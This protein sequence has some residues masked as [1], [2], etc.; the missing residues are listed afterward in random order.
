MFR[1]TILVLAVISMILH[2]KEART[3]RLN[4]KKTARILITPGRT[5]ILS[6]P[7]K[8]TKV[9]L[10]NRGSFAIEYVEQ[11][12]AISALASGVHGNL[13]VYMEGRRYA[14]DL[15][16]TPSGGDEIILVRDSTDMQMPAKF[17]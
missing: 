10:G 4:D 16:T 5:T 13:F 7:S 15:T 14:F 9:I 17:K 3:V 12:L 1:F 8:P 6:F 11:D 2:A